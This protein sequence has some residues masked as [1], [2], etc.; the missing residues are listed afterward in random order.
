L[1]HLQTRIFQK[2]APSLKANLITSLGGYFV[3]AATAFILSPVIIRSLGDGR[4]GAWS[5]VADLVGYYSLL[6]IGITGAVTHYVARF[7]ARNDKAASRSTLST[8]FCILS[9]IGLTAFIAGLGFALAFPYLFKSQGVNVRE[10]QTAL[11]VMST[12]IGIGFPMAVFGASLV[13]HRR[14]D[15]VN[16]IEIVVRVLSAVVIWGILA[17]G[18]KIIAMAVAT[19]VSRCV[20]WSAMIASCRRLGIQG[21]AVQFFSRERLKDVI[22]YGSKNALINISTL[23]IYRTDS[24]IIGMFLG[25]KWITA[26]SIGSMLVLYCSDACS[27]LTRAFT[28]HLTH[29]HSEEKLEQLKQLFLSGIRFSGLLAATTAAYLLAFGKSF[30]ELWVGQQYVTGSLQTRSDIIMMVMLA[31]NFPRLLQSISWQF[32]F[33]TRN[34]K[35][36]L[37]LTVGE[38]I[39]NLGLSIILVRHYGPL[40][41]ALGTAIPLAITHCVFLPAYVLRKADIRVGEY[42]TEGIGRPVIVGALTYGA[43]CWIIRVVDPVRWPVF[44]VEAFVALVIGAGLVSGLGFGASERRRLWE[45]IQARAPQSVP[46]DIPA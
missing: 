23:I 21:P 33:A 3:S 5:L 35:F 26:F 19:A 36:L 25:M 1:L 46:E 44:I 29:L 18:G 38:A 24:L 32:L 12:A 16:V 22:G 7:Q 41:V 13:G 31:G 14:M 27:A 40:G 37:W 2:Q 42:V 4:Y 8:A 43:S 9:G 20:S 11:A 30:I 34:Q 15:I 28:P 39:A 45:R 10:V 17:H 6:D